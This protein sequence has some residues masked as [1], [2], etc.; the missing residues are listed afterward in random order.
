MLVEALGLF[1]V[2]GC[3]FQHLL[4]VVARLR[5]VDGVVQTEAFLYLELSKQLYDWGAPNNG[6]A[7]VT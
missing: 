7:R 4:D 1:R 5:E 6:L 3:R 2:G